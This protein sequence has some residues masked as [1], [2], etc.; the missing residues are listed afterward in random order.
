MSFWGCMAL[1]YSLVNLLVS[2]ALPLVIH[3]LI[4]DY[5]IQFPQNCINHDYLVLE[6]TD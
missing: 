4:L 3:L 6:H 1:N 5:M 2:P